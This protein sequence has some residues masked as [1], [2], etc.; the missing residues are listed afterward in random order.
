M[1]IIYSFNKKGYEADCWDKEIRAISGGNLRLI[2]FNHGGYLDPS[3]YSEAIKLDLIYQNRNTQLLSMYAALQE[4]IRKEKADAL[5]VANA[6]PYHPD[7]LKKLN[8]YKALY[9]ADDP[10]ATYLINIPY[11]HAYNHVFYVDP[12]YSPD[13]D[14]REKMHYCG[15]TNA[16]WLP[17]SAFNF[18]CDAL[19]TEQQ[20][21]SQK[22]D[23]DVVYVGKFWRQ[24]IDTLVKVKRSLGTA[25]KMYGLFR[26]KHNLYLNIIHRYGA[27]VRPISYQERVAIYQRS[28]IG[29]NIHWNDYGLGNQRLYHLPANGVMQI[30]DCADHVG[31]IFEPDRE[32]VAYHGADELV[33][34]IRYYLG[35]EAERQDIAR[36]GYRRVMS[37]YRF[38]EVTRKAAVLI[39][40]GM[41]RLSWK[42]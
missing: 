38:A 21:F 5:I 42:S 39:Q 12:V 31:R 1:Q 7:F 15:M 14:M 18:E 4:L 19:K 34:K 23:I 30:T 2:P 32:V 9:S 29:F 26:L 8:V 33:E 24:K 40:E 22:R 13:M 20:L 41:Q 35:H 27:W 28:R 16:D 17:I 25:F 10:G 36:A 3:F 6:P 37:E 11:L